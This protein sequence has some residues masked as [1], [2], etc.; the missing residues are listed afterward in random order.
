M[1]TMLCNRAKDFRLEFSN[2][3]CDDEDEYGTC[4]W[5]AWY[6]FSKTGRKVQNNVKAY[7]R[8]RDGKIIEHSDA[9]S[10]GKWSS[11]AL[12]FKG[13]MLGWTGFMQR[14]IQ[15]SSRKALAEWMSKS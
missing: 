1:W 13:L 11:Q 10:L 12:G 7:M 2:I 5:T 6:T 3:H 9:F 15:K 8:I 4:N 14:K